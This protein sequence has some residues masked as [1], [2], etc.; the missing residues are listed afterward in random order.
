MDTMYPLLTTTPVSP[1]STLNGTIALP[2]PTTATVSTTSPSHPSAKIETHE[3][4]YNPMHHGT[5]GENSGVTSTTTTVITD[6]LPT[7]IVLPQR[8]TNATNLLASTSESSATATAGGIVTNTRADTTIPFDYATASSVERDNYDF[9][10]ALQL[11][12]QEQ[13]QQQQ[14]PQ[15]LH[16]QPIVSSPPPSSYHS[17]SM[18]SPNEPVYPVATIRGTITNEFGLSQ[19]ELDQQTAMMLQLEENKQYQQSRKNQQSHQKQQGN[20]RVQPM[21]PQRQQQQQQPL[22]QEQTTAGN[23]TKGSCNIM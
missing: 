10:M 15:Q 6:D 23:N 11:Q 20:R 9:L 16:Q 21:Q 3:T 7:A 5:G 4:E 19:E 12:L 14:Q 8:S 2:P 17:N 22:R 18:Q 1:P 13:E